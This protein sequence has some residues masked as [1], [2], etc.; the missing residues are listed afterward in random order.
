MSE[1]FV[2]DEHHGARR[3]IRWQPGKPE[4]S[5]WTGIK[6]RKASQLAVETWRCDR[7]AYLESYAP[8]V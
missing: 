7:C 2:M 5:I 1:G 6:Q 8:K 3:V 4:K